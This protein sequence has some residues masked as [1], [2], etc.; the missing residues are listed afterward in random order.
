MLEHEPKKPQKDTVLSF[1]S[2]VDGEIYNLKVNTSEKN[3]K[4][5]GGPIQCIKI[6]I[7][8]EEF[9]KKKKT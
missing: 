6:R 5:R 4:N 9:L 7:V 8:Q 1:N 2:I 3:H